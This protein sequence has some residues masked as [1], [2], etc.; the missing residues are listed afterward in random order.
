M[1]KKRKTEQ[2]EK[3][4]RSTADSTKVIITLK[5]N[6]PNTANRKYRRSDW[7]FFLEKTPL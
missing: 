4:N 6:G 1:R 7:I 3:E 5:L 2:I